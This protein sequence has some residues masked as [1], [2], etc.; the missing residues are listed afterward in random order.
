MS[1]SSPF[2]SGSVSARDGTLYTSRDSAWPLSLGS[3]PQLWSVGNVAKALRAEPK[4]KK[5]TGKKRVGFVDARANKVWQLS[6]TSAE[7][8]VA[9]FI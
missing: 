7:Y 1:V 2:E 4:P 3:E 5:V 9:A 6:C 8:Q